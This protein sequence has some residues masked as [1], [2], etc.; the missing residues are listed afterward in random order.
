MLIYRV[1]IILLE[2]A[3]I[4]ADNTYHWPW[5][6]LYASWRNNLVCTL[7]CTRIF[8]WNWTTKLVKCELHGKMEQL[9]KKKEKLWTYY[10]RFRYNISFEENAVFFYRFSRF[11]GSKFGNYSHIICFYGQMPNISLR[12]IKHG[13]IFKLFFFIGNQVCS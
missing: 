4:I 13:K 11:I 6:S 7:Q 10:T 8:L 5:N 1:I 12:H 2:R 3:F 9:K